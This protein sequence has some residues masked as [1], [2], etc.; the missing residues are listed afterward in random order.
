MKKMRIGLLLLVLTAFACARAITTAGVG[1]VD[2]IPKTAYDMYL[3][4]APTTEQLRAVF[5]KDPDSQVE[6]VPYSVQITAASGT[7]D[8]AVAF[9]KRGAGYRRL[10]FERVYFNG[11]PAGYLFMTEQHSFARKH[12]EVTFFERGGKIYFSPDEV[13]V[14]D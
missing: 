6:V 7:V 9:I 2:S 5:L 11:R 13:G 1:T 14:E 10:S 12:I 8:D 3:Y 4:T